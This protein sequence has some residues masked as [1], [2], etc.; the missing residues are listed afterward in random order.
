M[1]LATESDRARYIAFLQAQ[2]L[3]LDVSCGPWKSTRSSEQNNLLWGICYP[4][5]VERTGYT[6]EEIHEY[7]L[8]KH[9]GWVDKRVPKT[10]RNPEGIESV[11][12]RTTTRDENG[13]RSVLS[14][15]EFSAFLDTVDRI[16][17]EAGVFVPRER[18]A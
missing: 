7:V 17:A 1:K 14:K 12:R 16:S 2:A 5:L 10:P 9:F 6:A 4:P 13:K 15:A 11:P 18:A 3:P 8:G